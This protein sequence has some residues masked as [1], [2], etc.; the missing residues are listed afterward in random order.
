MEVVAWYL[1][2]TCKPCGGL[3]LEK[4]AGAPTLSGRLCKACHGTKRVPLP[5]SEAHDW[6]SEHMAKLSGIAGSRVM[7]K[8]ADDL[9]DL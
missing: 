9:K 8:I 1:Y 7:R 3:G 6:L 5:R 4:V 2:G